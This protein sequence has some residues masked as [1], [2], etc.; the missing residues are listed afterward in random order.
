M[1]RQPQCVLSAL[2]PSIGRGARTRRVGGQLWALDSDARPGPRPMVLPSRRPRSRRGGQRS[3]RR[4]SQAQ[5][6]ACGQVVGGAA[7]ASE[8]PLAVM[9]YLTDLPR[10]WLPGQSAAP[11]E[12]L[13]SSWDWA[14]AGSRLP[15]SCSAHVAQRS[16]CRRW[17][18]CCHRFRRRPGRDR[19][20]RQR[21]ARAPTRIG[22]V[23]GGR[24]CRAYCGQGATRHSMRGT[25]L[26]ACRWDRRAA[27][28]L[29][30]LKYDGR[31]RRCAPPLLLRPACCRHD[32]LPA[33]A[34]T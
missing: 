15:R 10:Q 31:E 32:Q 3:L 8:S 1:N 18:P 11:I 30:E 14:C 23:V 2:Q 4:R 22:D 13:S 29:S 5:L 16:W 21:H 26:P 34:P 17:L 19:S 24:R 7:F 9:T 6:H 12:H 20:T 33:P 28:V 27:H 25:R